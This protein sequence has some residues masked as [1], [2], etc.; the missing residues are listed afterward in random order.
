MPAPLNRRDFLQDSGESA[1]PYLDPEIGRG[2]ES[3]KDNPKL[4][5]LLAAVVMTTGCATQKYPVY[6]DISKGQHGNWSEMMGHI[7]NGNLSDAELAAMRDVS[8]DMRDVHEAQKDNF[9]GGNGRGGARDHDRFTVKGKTG[10][11]VHGSMYRF[12]HGTGMHGSVNGQNN[13][14]TARWGTYYGHDCPG[15]TRWENGRRIT[16]HGVPRGVNR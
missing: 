13:S 5:A 4:M 10:N 15:G 8:E 7:A 14:N 2:N 9:P 12:S 11:N 16:T 1:I 6:K 3:W